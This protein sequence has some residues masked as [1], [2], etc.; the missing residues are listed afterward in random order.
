MSKRALTGLKGSIKKWE[1]IL[2]DGGEERGTEDCPL[3]KLYLNSKCIACLIYKNNQK[4]FCRETPY[5]SWYKHHDDEHFLEE[6]RIIYC[7]ECKCLAE[8]ELDFLKSLL[9]IIK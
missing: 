9:P 2:L 6:K 7:D 3:C 8:A 1:R 4:P 5:G